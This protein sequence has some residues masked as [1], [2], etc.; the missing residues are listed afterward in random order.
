CTVFVAVFVAVYLIVI[1]P[2]LFAE[3]LFD[4][5]LA[6]SLYRRVGA[7]PEDHWAWTV[8]RRTYL[9]LAILLLFFGVAGYAMQ[10]AVPEAH[11]L[12]QVLRMVGRS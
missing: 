11:T 2:S 9:L 12:G 3:V 8:F 7:P 6:A 5:A 10:Y 4:G 1:A